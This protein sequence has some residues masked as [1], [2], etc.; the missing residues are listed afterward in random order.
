MLATLTGRRFDSK[1]W[2]VQNQVE[3]GSARLFF[4]PPNGIEVT[5]RLPAIAEVLRAIAGD[6]CH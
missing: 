3:R 2:A 4:P 1:E 5:A 6:S